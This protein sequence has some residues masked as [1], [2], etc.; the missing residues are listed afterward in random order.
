MTVMNIAE[1]LNA[2]LDEALAGDDRVMLIGEDVGKNGGVF[3]ISDG[4]QATHGDARVVDTPVAESGIIGA[5]FGLAV[6]GMRPIVEIQFMGFSYPGFDQIA[7]HV[8]RIRNRSRHRFTAPM[9]I[10]MPFG[11]GLG[12]AEHHSESDESLYANVPGLK[13]VVPSTPYDAKGLLSAAVKDPD[14]VIFLEPIRL[15]RAVKEDIPE[16]EFEVPIGVA[17]VEREGSDATIVSYG[18]MTKECRAAASQL[19][20]EGVSVEL[21]DVRTLVPLDIDTITASVEKTGRAVVVNEAARTGGYAGEIVAQIQEHCL[22]ALHAPIH[23]IT[24]WDTVFPLKRTEDYYIPS[25][26]RIVDAVR[27]TLEG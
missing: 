11:G 26:E 17:R 10:R 25:V 18:A 4:L 13:I 1:A 8:S 27:K 2:G 3:R 24:G 12:A 9:V 22:Y 20:D 14:P 16:G 23:R 15:Y 5:A 21:I 6:G 19:E 7:S